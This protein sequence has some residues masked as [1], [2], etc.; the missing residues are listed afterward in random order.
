MRA[1]GSRS[2]TRRAT[3][4]PHGP[5]PTTRTSYDV[6]T[7]S[8]IPLPHPD[9]GPLL[10]GDLVQ[11]VQLVGPEEA[12]ELAVHAAGV[13]AVAQDRD[14]LRVRDAR[15]GAPAVGAENLGLPVPKG[16]G[17]GGEPG[18]LPG[19]EGR[20]GGGGGLPPHPPPGRGKPGQAHP[21]LDRL[22]DGGSSRPGR[23]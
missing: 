23:G 8:V 12:L 22:A 5:V 18:G 3:A 4:L 16:G 21:R 15:L 10:T 19:R 1:A 11:G 13:A 2:P 6:P 20:V 7:G 9:E 14:Q 17:G